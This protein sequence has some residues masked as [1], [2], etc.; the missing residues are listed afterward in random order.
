MLKIPNETF[1]WIT[2][3]FKIKM[4]DGND[5]ELQVE[6]ENERWEGGEVADI[7]SQ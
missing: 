2:R 1:F 6:F 4:R 5:L 3:Y 7:I